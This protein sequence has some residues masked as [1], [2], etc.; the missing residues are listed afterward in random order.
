MRINSSDINTVNVV[1]CNLLTSLER[2]KKNI[3]NSAICVSKPKLV[4]VPDSVNLSALFVEMTYVDMTEC[5]L[6]CVKYYICVI[7]LLASFQFM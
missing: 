6:W 3:S 4:S 7:S 2:T 5:W 1:H